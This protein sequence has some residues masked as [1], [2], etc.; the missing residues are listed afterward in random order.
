MRSQDHPG[1]S[2]LRLIAAL[3]LTTETIVVDKPEDED[4][5]K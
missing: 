2:P 1:L 5:A 4:E 3:L